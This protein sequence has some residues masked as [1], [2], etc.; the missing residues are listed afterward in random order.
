MEYEKI[1][2][3]LVMWLRLQLKESY[4]KGL[5]VGVSGGIDSAV[6]ANLIKK[7]CPQNSLGI[8]L[9]I[10]SSSSSI[11]DAKM[12]IEQCGIKSIMIDLSDEHR[13]ILN[14]TINGLKKLGIFNP[15][16]LKITDAN[17]RARLRMSTLYTIAN[18]LGY[19]VVGTDNADE[20]YTGYFTKYR[21]NYKLSLEYEDAKRERISKYKIVP[22]HISKVFQR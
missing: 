8:I 21:D 22:K 3:D 6:I 1:I 12:L 9:P 10:Q 15:E 18:N 20:T 17:L 7:A 11:D 14:K 5:L 2:N 16:T 13:E 19:M 4:L